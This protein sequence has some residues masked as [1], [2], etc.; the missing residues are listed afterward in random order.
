MA[1]SKLLGAS[2]ALTF[3]SSTDV[4]LAVLQQ[5][6]KRPIGAKMCSS[7]GRSERS[8]SARLHHVDEAH[9]DGGDEAQRDEHEQRRVAREREAHEDGRHDEEAHCEV[10]EGE[11]AVLGRGVAESLGE[12][13]GHL[14]Q[15]P[16]A[17]PDEDAG[18]VEEE[19]GVGHLQ[20]EGELGGVCGER[21]EHAGDARADVGAQHGGVHALHLEHSDA[22][23]GREG[24]GGDRGGLY[25]DGN[26]HAD[27]HRQVA[28]EPAHGDAD[29]LADLDVGHLPVD[30]LVQPHG[31]VPLEDRLEQ[32]DD[33]EEADAQDGQ[34]REEHEDADQRVRH[35]DVLVAE[36]VLEHRLLLERG[37][38]LGQLVDELLVHLDDL[39]G[40]GF[41]QRLE[42]VGR[43]LARE[44]R[45]RVDERLGER[46]Q[47]A[48]DR[49]E[50]Q[51][52]EDAHEVEHVVHRRG[53]EGAAELVGV[54]RLAEGDDGRGDR[55]ADVGAHDERDGLLHGEQRGGDHRDEDGGG[56]GGGLHEHGDHHAHQHARHGVVEDLRVLEDLGRLGVE[57]TARG[58]KLWQTLAA[59]QAPGGPV[60]GG[61]AA[62]LWRHPEAAFVVL[63]HPL[64]AHQPEAVGQE[65]E[66]AD[67]KVER[68]DDDAQPE[69]D[70]DDHLC[71]VDGRQLRPGNHLVCKGRRIHNVGRGGRPC[72]SASFGSER[73]GRSP[74][75][76]SASQSQPCRP[77]EAGVARCDAPRAA[78]ST[79]HATLSS[80][81]S[82]SYPSPPGGSIRRQSATLGGRQS[83]AAASLRPPRAVG[84]RVGGCEPG[85]GPV[86]VQA[87]AP[88][89][90]RTG[91]VVRSGEVRSRNGQSGALAIAGVVSA[92][93]HF[94]HERAALPSP[95]SEF[96]RDTSSASSGA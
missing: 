64:A 94:A 79:C 87:A 73:H 67:E 61:R 76:R 74:G 30:A 91:A 89:G 55:G 11:P 52:H 93:G 72:L 28:R 8:G 86:G 17:V 46:E 25:A 83:V 24:G 10:R 65:G 12:A 39:G 82:T 56:G 51:Q 75:V 16:D 31:D 96:E 18:Q 84:G 2:S 38:G 13:D 48:R 37:R 15:R 70:G 1:S 45:R 80:L 66:R 44:T 32:V 23:E 47:V 81:K 69:Q 50:R 22:H 88:A 5:M 7:Y 59:T 53:G 20:R 33:D 40:E 60:R 63:A 57:K 43:L 41:R 58:L 68:P 6:Q 54:A 77:K 19:V 9:E 62:S 4:D 71:P 27:E 29:T 34:R 90:L 36:E 3:L 78:R 21:G 35:L 49:L 95:A 92:C 85:T 26:P 42:D 14:A